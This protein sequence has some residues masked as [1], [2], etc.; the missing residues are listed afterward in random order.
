[1]KYTEFCPN[2]RGVQEM[3][4]D[5]FT[6]FS[7]DRKGTARRF[8]TKILHCEICHTFVRSELKEAIAEDSSTDASA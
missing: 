8:I 6:S 3:T 5:L 7:I 1:M 2:C 4:V